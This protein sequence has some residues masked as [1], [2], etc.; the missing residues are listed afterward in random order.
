MPTINDVASSFKM[1]K[2]SIPTTGE[3]I[4][5]SLIY[6]IDFT[7]TAKKVAAEQGR[8]PT[9]MDGVAVK[10]LHL[11]WWNTDK[12]GN[13]TERQLV[14]YSDLSDVKFPCDIKVGDEI[15]Y[16]YI[17]NEEYLN[18]AR[19]TSKWGIFGRYKRPSNLAEALIIYDA[20]LSDQLGLKEKGIIADLILNLKLAPNLSDEDLDKVGMVRPTEIKYPILNLYR[21]FDKYTDKT[22]KEQLKTSLT[23]YNRTA[24]KVDL[25]GNAEWLDEQACL[26]IY[27]ALIDR[28]K[29]RKEGTGGEVTPF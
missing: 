9:I 1:P 21:Y 25:S 18:I 5:K 11:H 7:K 16:C 20:S 24:K 19:V 10:F 2:N 8:Q 14:D 22:G 6:D 12:E 23:G 26:A 28:E 13:N 17:T 27:K 3:T 15:D 4:V 29:A